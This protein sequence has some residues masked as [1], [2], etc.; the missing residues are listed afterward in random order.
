GDEHAVSP[1]GRADV[2]PLLLRP[3]GKLCLRHR[4]RD[5]FGRR[6][7]DGGSGES[8][9][10]RPGR[11]GGEPHPSDVGRAGRFWV[12]DV[13]HRRIQRTAGRARDLAGKTLVPEPSAPNGPVHP[14]PV[15]SLVPR[16]V[17]LAQAGVGLV[18]QIVSVTPVLDDITE[19]YSTPP[20]AS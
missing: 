7:L 3:P 12:R 20:S 2:R 11:M 6:D 18:D 9:D 14:A 1:E 4:P 15:S 13:L 5:V 16:S 19:T 8:L 17:R 10:V